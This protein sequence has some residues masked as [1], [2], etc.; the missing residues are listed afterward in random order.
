MI[1]PVEGHRNQPKVQQNGSVDKCAY[2]APWWPEFDTIE[3]NWREEE[4]NGP[5][6]LSFD[7]PYTCTLMPVNG[8]F[9][10]NKEW[11]QILNLP[12]SRSPLG[13]APTVSWGQEE[14][15]K[16]EQDTEAG[17]A[18]AESPGKQVFKSRHYSTELSSV[19]EPGA[20]VTQVCGSAL[21]YPGGASVCCGMLW[22]CWSFL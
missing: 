14:D 17:R 22:G 16:I 3:H 7:P 2:H 21:Q 5:I 9:L 12:I 8:I 20:Q 11:P 6:K 18:R 15:W 19:W 1:R 13:K 10:F 4:R